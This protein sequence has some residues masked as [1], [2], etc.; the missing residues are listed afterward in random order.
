MLDVNTTTLGYYRILSHT[1]RVLYIAAEDGV[2]PTAAQSLQV[3]Q[4]F[5]EVET[6]GSSGL[7]P[8]YLSAGDPVPIA[9]VRI[10]F[11][12]HQDPSDPLA[13]RFPVDPTDFVYNL[14]DPA[15]QEQIRSLGASYVQWDV[16]F[17]TSFAPNSSATPPSFGPSSP[18]PAL[19]YLR[20]PFR[21]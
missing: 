7:G 2:M 17:D 20:L 19:R 15:V 18:R 11:A 8:T 3:R 13:Q 1:D 6:N 9:N 14:A 4:K 16:L 12:F 5:F 21:F 10:G